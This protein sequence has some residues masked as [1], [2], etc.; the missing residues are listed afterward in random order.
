M[1][2]L[3]LNYSMNSNSQV[4]SH[5]RKIVLELSKHFDTIDVITSE[6]FL[7]SPIKNVDIFSTR[8]KTGRPLNNLWRFYVVAIPLLMK[9]RNGTL[10]SHMT[11]VQ[12]ALIA[13][14]CRILNIR[15]VLWYAHKHSSIYLRTSYPFINALATSTVGSC[16]ISGKKVIPLGQAIDSSLIEN[17]SR[18]PKIPPKSWYH[19]GRIDPSKNMET[20]ISAVR[21][22]RKNHPEVS[23]HFYGAPSSGKFQN[24]YENLKLLFRQEN[25]ITFHGQLKS[26]DLAQASSRHDGFVHAFWGS[27]DKSVVEAIILK[28]IVVSVN[29]EY[30]SQFENTKVD[31]LDIF[32]EITRQLGVVYSQPLETTMADIERKFN[33]ARTSHE[34]KGWIERLLLLLKKREV[35]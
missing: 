18:L 2:L 7:D 14:P 23:L 30:L 11:D 28:R 20:I 25:W 35:L 33:T 8:W 17:I 4:F 16:P 21:L 22:L 34:L 24:Y 9:H 26:S 6:V 13:L 1:N 15:H 10:F 27:L 3:I 32:E 31:D 5:Q 12:S 29:P 19:V